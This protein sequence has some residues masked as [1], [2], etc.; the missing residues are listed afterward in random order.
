MVVDKFNVAYSL[1]ASVRK[2]GSNTMTFS[3]LS[4]KNGKR[5]T[6][7]K[8]NVEWFSEHR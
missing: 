8:F 6:T 2:S 3:V 4:R 5:T 7:Y 1:L